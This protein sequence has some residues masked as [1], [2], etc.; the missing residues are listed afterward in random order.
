MPFFWGYLFI[1]FF[2]FYLCGLSFMFLVGYQFRCFRY[3]ENLNGVLFVFVIRL[4]IWT[5]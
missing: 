3:A 4:L 1:Y 2:V 5:L